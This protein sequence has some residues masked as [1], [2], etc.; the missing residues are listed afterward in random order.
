MTAN[1]KRIIVTSLLIGLLFYAV[2]APISYVQR[3]Y[4]A[5]GGE[6]VGVF[7]PLLALVIAGAR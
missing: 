3:G 2:F 5:F 4:F 6:C 7:F 1:E